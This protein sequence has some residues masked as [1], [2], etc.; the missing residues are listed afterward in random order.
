MLTITLTFHPFLLQAHPPTLPSASTT[1]S[2][3]VGIGADDV[4]IESAPLRDRAQDHITML[5]S[6]LRT[7]VEDRNS[8]V[9][10]L[11]YSSDQIELER[12]TA[13]LY[14]HFK[15]TKFMKCSTTVFEY[16]SEY[17]CSTVG[18]S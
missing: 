3:D 17:N 12:V 4:T 2:T 1:P 5:M 15:R 7:L 16:Y 6:Q 9:K 8:L 18:P 10:K 13:L 11:G 14:V